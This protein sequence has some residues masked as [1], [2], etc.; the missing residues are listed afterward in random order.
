VLLAEGRLR[1]FYGFPLICQGVSLVIV[2]L[3]IVTRS[4]DVVTAVGIT[5]GTQ[6][7]GLAAILLSRR[8]RTAI[9]QSRLLTITETSAM[10]RYAGV[11]HAGN[12]VQ[13]LNYRT[14]TFVVNHFL[15]YAGVGL[16]TLA[17]GLAEMLW[18]ISRPAATVLFPRT[19]ALSDKD[20]QTK[21]VVV[22][23]RLVFYMTLAAGLLAA[24]VFPF[25]IPAF[26][27]KE[28]SGAVAP[29]LWLLP[30]VVSYSITNVVASLWSGMGRPAT[31]LMVSTVSLVVGVGL[32]VVLLPRFGLS[33]A[34][35]GVSLGY[36]AST[37]FIMVVLLRFAGARVMNSLV[38]PGRRELTSL[39]SGRRAEPGLGPED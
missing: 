33:G 31:N 27:G 1:L 9:V 12:V 13:V 4:L 36:I 18:L 38:P 19:A 22:G 7:L 10:V 32:A 3:V 39:L 2:A 26:Y 25:A 15:G 16:Y 11:S 34:A 8:D 29:F 14:A 30:G 21:L 37:A 28:F 23:L 17:T 20:A 35:A 24:A 5:I 6:V